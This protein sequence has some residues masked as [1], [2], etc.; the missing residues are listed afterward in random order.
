V[1]AGVADA[2]EG[3]GWEA[4]TGGGTIEIEGNWRGVEVG[5]IVGVAIVD[6]QAIVMTKTRISA[7]NKWE[8]SLL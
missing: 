3:G 1:I 5:S 4:R 8:E 2:R 6:W 7:I